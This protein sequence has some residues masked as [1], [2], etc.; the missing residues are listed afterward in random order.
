MIKQ[1]IVGAVCLP[2]LAIVL[3]LVLIGLVMVFSFLVSYQAVI[4]VGETF[5]EIWNEVLDD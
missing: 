3:T 4:Y 1:V 2:F 5:L